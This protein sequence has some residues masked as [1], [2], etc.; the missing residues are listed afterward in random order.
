MI[1]G[2]RLASNSMS[3]ELRRAARHR[4]LD[5]VVEAHVLDAAG[6]KVPAGELDQVADQ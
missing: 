6:W 2:S 3:G 5:H 1:T 4:L